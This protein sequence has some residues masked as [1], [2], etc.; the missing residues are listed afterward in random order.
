MTTMNDKYEPVRKDITIWVEK[1]GIAM[2]ITYECEFTRVTSES[3]P[4]LA[5]TTIEWAVREP[6]KVVFAS[7]DQEI[8]WHYGD[9]MPAVIANA[10]DRYEG[11][12]DDKLNDKAQDNWL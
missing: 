12:I 1:D 8:T 5:H 6:I 10:L 2:D 4:G 3:Q 11:I 9:N 7:D